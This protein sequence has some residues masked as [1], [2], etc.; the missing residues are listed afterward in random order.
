MQ[1]ITIVED[2]VPQSSPYKQIR[3]AVFN[4]PVDAR[5]KIKYNTD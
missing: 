3:R 4:L 2:D 5:G 1:S